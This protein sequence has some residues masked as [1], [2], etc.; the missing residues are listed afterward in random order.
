MTLEEAAAHWAATI[1][2]WYN[3]GATTEEVIDAF[4]KNYLD[5]EAWDGES[6]VDTFF[7]DKQGGYSKFLDTADREGLADCIEIARGKGPLPTYAERGGSLYN[8]A[9]RTWKPRPAFKD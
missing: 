8:K 7:R 1:N 5:K 4:N 9:P 2:G 6:Y 3:I